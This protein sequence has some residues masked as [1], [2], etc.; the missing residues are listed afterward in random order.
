M[1]AILSGLV[2]LFAQ[3]IFAQDLV[4]SDVGMPSQIPT[5]AEIATENTDITIEESEPAPIVEPR[6]QTEADRTIGVRLNDLWSFSKSANVAG[7][8]SIIVALEKSKQQFVPPGEKVKTYHGA[9]LQEMPAFI[10]NAVHLRLLI[11][12][13]TLKG[14]L[15]MNMVTV[16]S[17]NKGSNVRITSITPI[18]NPRFSAEVGLIDR[19]AIFT[20]KDNNLRISIPIGVGSFDDGVLN[21]GRVSLLTPRFKKAALTAAATI[22]ERHK[23]NYFAGKP[24]IRIVEGYNEENTAIGFHI[25]I[26]DSFHR[27]F[28]SHG[29]MRMRE[30]DLI[31]IH[32]L[33]KLA[34]NRIEL[35]ISYNTETLADHPA[36]KMN[37]YQTVVNIGT[38]ENPKMIIDRDFL[39]QTKYV[40]SKIPAPVDQLVDSEE[41]HYYNIYQY[42][43]MDTYKKQR[44]EQA[45]TCQAEYETLR[46]ERGIQIRTEIQNLKNP[47]TTQSLSEKDKKA[48]QKRNQTRIKDLERQ[49]KSL[50]TD[51]S[52][53]LE[54]CKKKGER[55]LGFK[56]KMYRAW[57]H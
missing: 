15:N 11:M 44:A 24:F 20:D 23:P 54:E 7:L 25:E 52:K 5:D 36:P 43:G 42:E 16:E 2:L 13:T 12:T 32:D 48:R 8:D 21:P 51:L 29:C 37:S 30:Q 47:M 14:R 26:N 57:V 17:S 31:M 9:I 33:V 10:G 27:A 4:A 35:S 38:K 19:K 3:N 49:M 39:V 18:H 41:D 34:Q 53:N 1:K 56:D 55:K 46:S 40:S 45:A 50:E 6:V 28:E 22:S